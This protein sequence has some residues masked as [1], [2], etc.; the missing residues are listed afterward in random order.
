[1]EQNKT[2]KYFKYAIGEI[3]LVVIGILIALQINNWNEQRK[4]SKKEQQILL[5][6]KEEFQQNIKELSFDH[7]INLGCLKAIITLLNFDSSREFETRFLDSLMGQ[8]YNFATFDARLGVINDISSSGNLELISDSNLRY[9]LNQWTGE[10]NDYKEDVIIRRDYWVHN[11][12][13]LTNKFLPIR[14]TDY[15]QDRKDYKRELILK[16]KVVSKK[17]YSDFMTNLEVD[18]MLFDYY[19]NQSFVTTNEEVIME[20]LQSTLKL[21]DRNINHD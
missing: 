8:A 10:L 17:N 13:P 20:F 12:S 19:M 9:A 2:S 14:N 3:I 21:I 1:M 7:N 6:L 11:V 5:S 16:P 15:F 18:G 4:E